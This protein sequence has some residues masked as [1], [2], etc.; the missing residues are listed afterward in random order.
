MVTN[1]IQTYGHTEW[2]VKSSIHPC[3]ELEYSIKL[4]K[5]I[6]L[7]QRFVYSAPA[8]NPQNPR[9]SFS[10]VSVLSPRK[11]IVLALILKEQNL[12]LFR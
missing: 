6:P 10:L 5:T 8:N 11:T 3:I 12:M 4:N 9:P 2:L 7:Q 1:F